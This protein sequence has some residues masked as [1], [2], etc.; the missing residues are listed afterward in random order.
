MWKWK[1]NVDIYF[2]SVSCQNDLDSGFSSRSDISRAIKSCRANKRYLIPTW[3][4]AGPITQVD[5]FS[6]EA[7]HWSTRCWFQC[8]N[9]TVRPSM[10]LSSRVPLGRPS[11]EVDDDDVDVNAFKS[12]GLT[13]GRGLNWGGKIFRSSILKWSRIKVALAGFEGTQHMPDPFCKLPWNN[14]TINYIYKPPS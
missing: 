3:Y 6:M 2:Y 7:S 12:C 14:T 5:T 11:I 10:L 9:E 1:F 8:V 4:A 13:C